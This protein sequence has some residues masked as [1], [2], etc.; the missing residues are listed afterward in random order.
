MWRTVRNLYFKYYYSRHIGS[1]Y[2]EMANQYHLVSKRRIYRFNFCRNDAASYSSDAFGQF[3]NNAFLGLSKKL[4]EAAT[5]PFSHNMN[6]LNPFK[7]VAEELSGIAKSFEEAVAVN[8]PVLQRAASYFLNITGKRFRPTV[9]ILMAYAVNASNSNLMDSTNSRVSHESPS[10]KSSPHI[11]PS[12]LKLAEI[13]ELIH[14]ASLLHDDVIDVADTRRGVKS[15]NALFGNQL[16]VLAGDFL[17]SRASVSLARLRNCDVV[18]MLSTVIEHL[19]HGEVLQMTVDEG[20][21]NDKLEVYLQKTFLK[22]AS[23]IANSCQAVALL[24]NC[25]KEIVKVAFEYGRHLGLAYQLMDDALDFTGSSTSLGKPALADI[26][27]GTLTAPVLFA[28]EQYPEIRDYAKRRFQRPDDISKTLLAI[29][30]SK[31]IER[32]VDLAKEHCYLAKEGIQQTLQDTSYRQALLE[33]ADFVVTRK[34]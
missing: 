32:T 28:M 4:Q 29:E 14:V 34:Q 1:R 8:H 9:V 25:P 19:V 22:T 26:H 18:E 24:S 16:S 10:V 31:G 11:L 6:S 2:C 23:L 21:S 15:V 12:Q 17:L 5:L 20:N 33:M 3:L 13:T 27:Q 7:L 30:N